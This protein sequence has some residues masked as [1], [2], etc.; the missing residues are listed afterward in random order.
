[1]TIALSF[2]LFLFGP[3]LQTLNGTVLDSAGGAVVGARVEIAGPESQRAASTNEAGAFSIDAIPPGHYSIRITANGFAPY[4]GSIQVPSEATQLTLQ[5]APHSDD[6]IVTTTRVETPLANVGV[7]ATVL[8]RNA[9]AE[10]QAAPVLELLRNVPGLAVSNTSRR[11]GT[12]SIYTRGGGQEANLVLLDGIEINDP[13]GGFNFAHLMPTNV[14]R[15]EVVRGPQSASYGSNAAASAIQVVSHKGS[16]EDGPASG[17]VSL[18]AGTFDTYKYGTGVYGAVKAF[19]YSIAADHLGTRG[20]YTNDGYRNL[21]L[22]E[23]AGYRVNE[24]S[25]IRLTARTIGSWVGTPNKVDY[26]LVDPDAFRVDHGIVSG[27]RYEAGSSTFSHHIQL[28]FTRLSDYFQDNIGEGPFRIGAIVKG[29]PAAR[30]SAGVR[31]VRFLS[32]TDL[33]SSDY[34]I[35]A[36][37]SLV[38]KT[39][40]LSPTGISE[41]ITQRRSAEY[42][43]GWNYSAQSSLIFGYDFEQER[44]VA[45]TAPPLRNNHGI[46]VSHHHKIG[47]KLFLTESV[48]LENNS[49]FHRKATPRFSASYFLTSTTRLKGSGGTGITEPSFIESYSNDPTFV[50]NRNLKPEQ[51][52]SIEAGIEQHFL[53]SALVVD[54]TGF[55]T[56]FHDLIVF[57]FPAAPALP[58]WINLDASRARGIESNA[59]VRAAWLR[60]HGQYTFLDTRVTASSSPASASTGIGQELPH[61]PRHSGSI[62]AT[63]VFR[64]GFVNLDTTFTGERQDSDG[65]GFGVVRNPRYE[66]VDLGGSYALTSSADLFVRAG[67]LLNQHY[68]EVLGYPALSRNVMAG[69]KLRWGR[70]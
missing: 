7:S 61:R 41:T 6:V 15:I 32:S 45:G 27:I 25:Q 37:T 55:N 53:R 13:G 49:V 69:M 20:E 39:V 58:T 18:E 67:N 40:T 21:T 8:D 51:S 65:V 29:T 17:F 11:G 38:Q 57:V 22:A 70:R 10:H 60:V 35:P 1:M 2:L 9:I 43:G 30:G 44:G 24:H 19:D 26:G 48:R 36:G 52:R 28:G 14:D 66:R 56:A 46:F 23:N 34:T 42:Q 12:T 50:G 62:D 5:V 16:S 3:Q 68:E 31:L 63:V 4:D 54:V 33:A 64:R 47:S 59:T